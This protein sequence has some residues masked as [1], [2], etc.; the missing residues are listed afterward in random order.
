[1]SAG[2]LLALD[3]NP[4]E[5]AIVIDLQPKAEHLD[6]YELKDIWG[7][8]Y[9]D[10]TPVALRVEPL[11]ANV[12]PIPN[13][14]DYRWCFTDNNYNRIRVHE[15][16]YLRGGY[17]GGPWNWGPAGRVNGAMLWPDALKFFFKKIRG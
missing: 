13:H 14:D 9:P 12:P 7:F 6:Y 16:L 17:A 10:W 1:M 11:L 8:S 2:D 5:Y 4:Y 3:N 15:F